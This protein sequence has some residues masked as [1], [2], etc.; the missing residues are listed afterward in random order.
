[1]KSNIAPED[2]ALMRGACDAAWRILQTA[3]LFPSEEYQKSVR[4]RMAG[5]AM[6]AL[7][8]GERDPNQ[9]KAIAQIPAA[10][11]QPSRFSS[12]AGLSKRTHVRTN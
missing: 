10:T 6:A 11:A 9:L 1:M 4:S 8:D 2:V 7:E 3:L 12:A 5:R